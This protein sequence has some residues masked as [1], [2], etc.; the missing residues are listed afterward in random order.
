MRFRDKLSEAKYHLNKI[1][2]ESKQLLVRKNAKSL[3]R[4]RFEISSFFSSARS[5][6]FVIQ[7]DL[8]HNIG[9]NEWYLKTKNKT[10]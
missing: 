3:H 6:T 2:E 8:S 4:F 7:K 5:V 1:K 9:F 10:D